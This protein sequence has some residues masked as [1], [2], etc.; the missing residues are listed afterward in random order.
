MSETTAATT[1]HDHPGFGDESGRTVPVVGGI[2][3][4]YELAP[5]IED[6]QHAGI[7]IRG[8]CSG[9]IATETVD[10][11]SPHGKDRAYIAFD[12]MDD[13]VEFFKIAAE[14]LADVPTSAMYRLKV[15]PLAPYDKP[16]PGAAVE[17]DPEAVSVLV[18]RR[19]DTLD[20]SAWV[21]A[22]ERRHEAARIHRA[23]RGQPT[24]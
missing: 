5:L 17:F 22:L 15:R 3:R 7:S 13:A 6:L 24:A 2:P 11:T 20:G 14:R 12:D 8:C 10:G 21:R 9:R 23:E 18:A 4:D 1:R 16:S 19:N